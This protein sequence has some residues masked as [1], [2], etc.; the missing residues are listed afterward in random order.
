MGMRL[1]KLLINIFGTVAKAQHP[2]V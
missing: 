2:E 1:L